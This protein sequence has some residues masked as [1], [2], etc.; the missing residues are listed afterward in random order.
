MMDFRATVE[1]PVRVCADEGPSIPR[2]VGH[3]GFAN[4]PGLKIV[5]SVRMDIQM[6]TEAIRVE[7]RPFRDYI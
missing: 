4:A 3:C 7:S 2:A 6:P 5:L 1:R